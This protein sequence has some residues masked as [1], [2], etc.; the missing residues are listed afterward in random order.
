MTSVLF[1]IH[2]KL[3]S[4]S[5]AEQ[6]IGRYILNHTHAVIQMSTAELAAAAD[7]STATVARFGKT[8]IPDGGYPALKLQ[9]SAECNV[10]QSLYDEINPQDDLTAVKSKLALRLT[11]TIEETNASLDDASLVK[12]SQLIAEKDNVYVYGLGASNVAATDFEQKFIRVGKA[13]IHSQ[14][15]HLLAV[16]LTTQR[17]TAVLFLVSNSGEKAESLELARLAHSMGVPIIVLTRNP[18]STLGKLATIIL[19]NDDSEEGQ[20]ARA[21]ATTSLMAQLYVIDLL[22][23]TFIANDYDHHIEQ[24]VLSRD[25]IRKHFN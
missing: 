7:V 11:H 14:D 25:A 6:K 17:E 1:T 8:L 5:N 15:T 22:Y 20:T 19:V 2:E 16:G 24:L 10:D 18:G 3:A 23:Y 12:A 4:F 9:L 21:A 13:V